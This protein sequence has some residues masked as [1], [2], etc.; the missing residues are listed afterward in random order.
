MGSCPKKKHT[1]FEYDDDNEY[2]DDGVDVFKNKLKQELK[3]DNFEGFKVELCS[4]VNTY[5]YHKK[6]VIGILGTS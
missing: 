6:V 5:M 1:K 4:S 3:W 2:V